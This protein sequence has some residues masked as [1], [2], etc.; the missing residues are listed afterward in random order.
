MKVRYSAC[1]VGL[2][3]VPSGKYDVSCLGRICQLKFLH[4]HVGQ[5]FIANLYSVF[6]NITGHRPMLHPISSYEASSSG[7]VD[8]MSATRQFMLVQYCVNTQRLACWT[9]YCCRMRTC[10]VRQE[11]RRL[12]APVDGSEV[13]VDADL[14]LKEHL[15][16]IVGT[17]LQ[18]P[19]NEGRVIETRH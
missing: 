5:P 10:E 19:Y 1:T 17:R 11:R 15:G 7:L 18:E 14:V 3:D 6:S 8:F 16:Q 2:M 9:V 4:F 13:P 12:G